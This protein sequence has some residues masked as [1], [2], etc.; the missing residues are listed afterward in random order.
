MFQTYTSLRMSEGS[1]LFGHSRPVATQLPLTRKGSSKARRAKLR[2][3]LEAWNH[4][5]EMAQ[6][7]AVM[8]RA[9]EVSSSARKSAAESRAL[10]SRISDALD[11]GAQL[12]DG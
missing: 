2:A 5:P 8:E 12:P 3:Q 1:R 9:R 10:M 6:Q 4:K 11:Q 7:A